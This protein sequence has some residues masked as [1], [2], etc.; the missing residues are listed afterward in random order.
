MLQ[1]PS[2]GTVRKFRCSDSLC[3]RH[4]IC[5]QRGQRRHAKWHEYLPNSKLGHGLLQYIAYGWWT[6]SLLCCYLGMGHQIFYRLFLPAGLDYPICFQG[7]CP[8]DAGLWPLLFLPRG[9]AFAIAYNRQYFSTFPLRLDQ[10]CG[11]MDPR[12]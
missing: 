12:L 6:V 11:P 2:T 1:R 10:T 3:R 9:S 8:S 7:W 5:I 4:T